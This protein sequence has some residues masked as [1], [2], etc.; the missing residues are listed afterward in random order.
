MDI[1][2]T[3]LMIQLSRNDINLRCYRDYEIYLQ[4]SVGQNM[5]YRQNHKNV[6][7][8][9]ENIYTHRKKCRE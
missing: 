2:L 6:S 3:L 4:F 8:S 7:E 9:L 1:H 5:L